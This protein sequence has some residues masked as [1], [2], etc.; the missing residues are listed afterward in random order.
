M[1]VERF[2]DTNVLLYGYDLDA[3]AKREVALGILEAALESASQTAV[4]VQVLLEFHV[5]F[6]RQNHSDEE[7]EEIIGDFGTFR[8]IENTKSLFLAGLAAKR[9]WKLSLWDAMIVAAAQAS[10]AAEL[11]T[12]DLNHG[13]DYGGVRVVNPFLNI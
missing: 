9:R 3:A 8:L 12:E 1:P 2:L 11:Y 13:Q 4:S 6:T 5:N 7:A 10:G